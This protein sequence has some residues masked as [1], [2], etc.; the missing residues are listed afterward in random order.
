MSTQATGFAAYGKSFQEKIIQALLVDKQFAEQML[1]V[2]NVEYF[3]LKHLQYLAGKYFTYSKKYKDF[4][5]LNLLVT[6]IKDDLKNGSDVILR[7]QIIELLQRIKTNPDSGDLPFVKE[8]SLDFCRKQA[9]KS[10]LEKA[11]DLVSTEKY[12][13]IVEVIRNAVSVGTT[14]SVGHDFMNDFESR[15]VRLKREVV[16]T[17]ME[18]LD[19]KEI[20]QGGLGRGEIGVVVGNTGT[21]KSHFLVN[22]GCNAMR[23]GKN[24]LHYTFELSETAVAVRYDSNLCDMNSNEVLDSKE[25]ILKKYSEMKL[26]R[27]FIKEYPTSTCTVHMI[28]NHVEKL[29]L[30]GFIPDV[31]LIDYADIMRSSRQFD[32]LRHELKLIYEELRGLATE[33]Q[34][35]IWTASQ[36]NRDSS[37]S[38]IV[39]LE[40][41]SEAYGKAM[42]ADVILTISRRSHEKASGQGRLFVAKNRAGRDGLVYPVLIDTSRSVFKVTGDNIT[43][44]AAEEED[45]ST[46]KQALRNKWQ[47]LQKEDIVT[48]KKN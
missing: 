18:H 34:I 28:R 7:D 2:M 22:L 27:L 12:E 20:L 11:V 6:I 24:V 15:F 44:A 29:S 42:V 13:S 3:E 48:A 43:M 25:S 9:L 23:E 30:K 5:T 1:E 38:E 37:N 19:K 14:P 16:P 39:G 32:S 8:K 47:E 45:Q 26:G 21:G 31:I 36:A 41:M 33:L 4:P 10:A 46:M 35:P 40:S 17:G